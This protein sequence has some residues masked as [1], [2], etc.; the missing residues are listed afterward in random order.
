MKDLS[1]MFYGKELSH[2]C[3][4]M[5]AL[6]LTWVRKVLFFVALH[7]KISIFESVWSFVNKLN[8]I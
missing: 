3:G 2:V 4:Y 6:D 1:S 5:R 7:S 8:N